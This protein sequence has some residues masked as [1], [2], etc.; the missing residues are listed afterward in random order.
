MWVNQELAC[1]CWYQETRYSE[2]WGCK[3]RPRWTYN[4]KLDDECMG[5]RGLNC[6]VEGVSSVGTN[7]GMS[8]EPG[9][10]LNCRTNVTLKIEAT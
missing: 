3:E 4:I 8:Q 6:L 2:N 10:I 5:A 9:N 1:G 7:F